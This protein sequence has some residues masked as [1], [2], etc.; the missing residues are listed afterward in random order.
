[1]R[2]R[3][4]LLAGAG[5]GA[6]ALTDRLAT[7]GG[8]APASAEA[9]P[10][11]PDPLQQRQPFIGEHQAGVVTARR[12]HGLVVA[13]DAVATRRA[14]LLDAIAMLSQRAQALTQGY[15]ALLGHP[16]DG[17][18]PD[19][20]SLGP[21]VAP[22]GLTVTIG[23]GAAL[24]DD[25]FGLAARRPAGLTTMPAFADDDLDPSQCHGDVLLQLCAGT[26]ETVLHAL[27]DLLRA[28]R[29]GFAIRWQVAGFVAAPREPGAGRNHLGFKDGTANP[30]P[31]DDALMRQLVW[32]PEGGTF[33]AVR[34]I[35][36]RVE[37]WDR[38][39]RREQELMI[40]RDKASGAPLGRRREQD[41]PGYA[42]DPHGRRI[43]LDAHIR[44]ARPRTPDTEGQRLLRRP[45]LYSRG[46]DAAGQLDMGLLFVAFQRS[47]QDQFEVVQ[48]RLAGEPMTDYV[49]PVGGGYFFLPPGARDADDWVGSRL[50]T[51]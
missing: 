45:Y 6:G 27:R 28:T 51:G 19:G 44:L 15:D 11:T 50:L 32:T 43:P 37:F 23:F 35:R 40:G 13:L 12:P 49:V 38:V 21:R 16:T 26:P 42:D 17:P 14:E 48:R 20:G 1:M 8:V 2:R 29:G 4:F 18:T 39:G 36:N 25:R 46:A 24:F 7:A 3:Q 5:L 31:A 34:I 47:L 30:D 41:D 9:G 10:A 33:A 22:D